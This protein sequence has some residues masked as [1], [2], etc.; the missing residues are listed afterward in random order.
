MAGE[1]SCLSYTD[2]LFSK[3]LSSTFCMLGA[4]LQRQP[5]RSSCPERQEPVAARELRAV[6]S[7]GQVTVGTQDRESFLEDKVP[8]LCFEG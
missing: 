3:Y 8:E 2:S 5:S 1:R 6:M 7:K 4:V